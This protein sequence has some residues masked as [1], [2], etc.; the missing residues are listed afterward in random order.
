MT[1]LIEGRIRTEAGEVAAGVCVSNGRE[2]V[3]TD[4]HGGYQLPCQTEDRFVFMTVPAGYLAAGKFYIDLKKAENFDFTLRH[5]P[6]GK[7][8]SF[9]F[10]QITDTHI[11][12]NKRAF[13][14]HLEDDLAR[15]HRDAGSLAQFIVASGDLTAGGGREEYQA[16]LR[17]VA[18]STLPV[19]HAAGNHDDDAEIQGA[20]FMDFLGPLYYSFD[21]GPVHF[22]VYDGEGHLRRNG[23][24]QDCWMRADLE[25]QYPNKPVIVINH[26][27]WGSEFYDQWKTFSIIATLSGHWHS[28]R[29]FADGGIVH[30]NTPSLGF[31]GIDQSPRAY[32]LFNYDQ[33]TLTSESRAL[34]SPNF[35]SGISFRPPPDNVLGVVHRLEGVLPEPGADWPLF[36][37]NSRRTGSVAMGPE[38]PL[39]LAWR[40]GTGGSIHIAAPLA[41]EGSIF[42]SAKNEDELAGNGIVAFDARQ[43]TLRW[44]HPTDAAIK[45]S[46]AYCNGRLFAVTVTGRV[47]GLAAE[48]GKPLWTYQLGDPSQRWVYSS[49]LTGAGRVYIGVSS[50]FVAL[51]QESGDVVWRRDDFGQNDFLPSYASPAAF[52]EY[53]V[54]A[55]Y[56]Q[57]VNLAV[58]KAATGEVVWAKMEGK[59]Y[60]TYSTPVV[61]NDGTIYTVSGG[62]IRALDIE[63]GELK[64]EIPFTPNRIHATPALAKGRLFVSTGGGMLHAF[65]ADSGA[66]VWRW[67][68]GGDRALFTPYVRE[69]AVTLTSPVVAGDFVYV[70]AANGFL[71][72]LDASTGTCVWQYNLKTPLAAPPTISGN[73]LW[74]GGCDGFVYAFASSEIA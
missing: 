40:A 67:A 51:D 41:A 39:S 58:L 72:A 47:L 55:F 61:D 52:D 74:V 4:I 9:S 7:S 36:H 8:A 37:G 57:P 48:T 44:R 12:V 31:G 27:P 24:N 16:Y 56:T 25:M 18:T 43:G 19:Y 30:Y 65:E 14:S 26:F 35:F 68:G 11:S 53:I 34:V 2:V 73:G 38:P 33:G 64:W 3:K 22:I 46:P 20:N 70:G 42:Q 69:G 17:A 6:E 54:V 1:K 60:H 59:P 50:H 63:T 28:C 15:I 32:R 23:T 29:L 49:P 5:H 13:A 71:Y 66:E 10:V 45:G 21:Y 62:A